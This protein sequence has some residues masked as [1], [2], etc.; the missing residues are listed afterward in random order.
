MK[1][2]IAMVLALTMILSIFSGCGSSSSG[3]AAS[4]GSAASSTSSSG[5]NDTSDDGIL[6]GK[7][8]CLIM[9]YMNSTLHIEVVNYWEYMCK[10]LGAEFTYYDMNNDVDKAI[11]LTQTAI[12]WGADVIGIQGRN[13]NEIKVA[14]LCDAAGVKLVSYFCDA[15]DDIHDTVYASESWVGAVYEDEVAAGYEMAQS[16]IDRGA[17]KFALVSVPVG[18]A[19]HDMRW[20]GIMNA[21]DATDGVEVVSEARVSVP[22]FSNA[23][24]NACALGDAIDALIVTGAGLDFAGQ[25]V[26]NSGRAGELLFSTTDLADNTIDM[27]DQKVITSVFGGHYVDSAL[28]FVLACRAAL[29][30]PILDENGKAPA[31]QADYMEF[32]SVEDVETYNQYIYNLDDGEFWYSVDE[33]KDMIT[34]PDFGYNAFVEECKGHSDPSEIYTRHNIS[35]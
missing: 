13:G 34:S 15:P 12:N 33:I 6:A 8:I 28:A 3:S 17:T 30:T 4:G 9:P 29:G 2:L 26:V 18:N 22:E 27:F 23:A 35:K 25:V 16:L 21:I 31:V 7:K 19:T 32:A 10:A 5:G 24:S 1:K 14:E 20:Q 11:D